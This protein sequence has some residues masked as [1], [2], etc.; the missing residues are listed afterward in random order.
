M[1]RCMSDGATREAAAT[2]GEAWSPPPTGGAADPEPGEREDEDEP[3]AREAKIRP[4]EKIVPQAARR[5]RT[6]RGPRAAKWG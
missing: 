5:R 6:D 3:R 2:S 4:S 1:R